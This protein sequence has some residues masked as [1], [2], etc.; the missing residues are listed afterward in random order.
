VTGGGVVTTLAGNAGLSGSADGTNSS[1]LFDFPRGVTVDGAGNAYVADFDND[2]IRKVTSNGVV[3]T[4][5]GAAGVIGGADGIGD[6]ADF[7]GPCGV[8]VDKN[9]I[10]YVADAGN[11]RISTGTPLPVMSIQS[12][13]LGVIVSWP[14]PFTSFVLQ[15]NSNIGNASGW[16]TARYS[17]GNDGTNKSITFSP[18]TGIL[19]FRL[20]AN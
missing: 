4:I 1:A 19:F 2:T 3:T 6:S 10:I 11:N 7:A 5:G 15:Q 18:S 14:A 16:S 12:S 13:A 9:G 17:I 8:A 20:M